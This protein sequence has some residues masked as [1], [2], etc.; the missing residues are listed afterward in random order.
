[1]E[2]YTRFYKERDPSLL[3]SPLHDALTLMAIIHP[4]MFCFESYPV[5]VVDK[6]DGPARGQSIAEK[7]PYENLNNGQK[8]HRI[9]F[10]INYEKFFRDFLSVMTGQQVNSELT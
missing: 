4:N 2:Y 1:M 10:D 9:A 3:G 5:I 7:R 8:T 6:L